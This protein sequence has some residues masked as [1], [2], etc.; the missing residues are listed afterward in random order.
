MGVELQ[1]LALIWSEIREVEGD[2]QTAEDKHSLDCTPQPIPGSDLPPWI[3]ATGS[4]LK[5]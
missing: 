4:R 2:S 5:L 1:E 3:V